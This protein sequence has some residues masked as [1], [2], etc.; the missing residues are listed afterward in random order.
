M[1][2][3]KNPNCEVENEVVT[4]EHTKLPIQI[5]K[6]RYWQAVLWCENLID[7]W[8]DVIDEKLQVP[9]AYCI[10]DKDVKQDGTPRNPHVHC[11]IAF[12]NTTTYK[13]ALNIFKLLG[14]NA[15]NTCEHCNNIRWCYDYLIHDCDKARKAH[16]HLYAPEER[17]CGNNFDIGFYEQVSASEKLEILNELVDFIIEEGFTNLIDFT[18]AVRNNPRFQGVEYTEVRLNKTATLD[19]YCAANW[20]SLQHR[21]KRASNFGKNTTQMS[22]QMSTLH[23]PDCGSIE[24]VKHG[25]T[26]GGTQRFSCKDCGKRFTIY[27]VY[28]V[29]YYQN[30]RDGRRVTKRGIFK[31]GLPPLNL[32][33]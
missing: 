26:A 31:G 18:I 16:K 20:K 19:R 22:T 29:T 1:S 27:H 7:D 6:G 28:F 33:V 5:T 25:K 21:S 30:R 3:E 10:H 12:P 15:V 13:H 23:C 17:I 11:I 8:Q 4:D 24:I 2:E 32:G 14:A 9:F